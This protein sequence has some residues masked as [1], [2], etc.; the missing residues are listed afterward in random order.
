M[1]VSISGCFCACI[2][3]SYVCVVYVTTCFAHTA[4]SFREFAGLLQDVEEDRMMMVGGAHF[5]P[6]HNKTQSII[7]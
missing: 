4:E 1:F 5:F 2:C 6:Y 7:I 3:I